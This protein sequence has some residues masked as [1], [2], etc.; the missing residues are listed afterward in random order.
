MFPLSDDV[1]KLVPGTLGMDDLSLT[2]ELV[3]LGELALLHTQLQELQGRVDLLEGG[4]LVDKV[5]DEGYADAAVVVVVGMGSGVV[6]AA[7]LVHVTVA[8]HQEVVA[9]VEPA[10]G[11]DVEGLDSPD[12]VLALGLY[13]AGLGRRVTYD[14]VTRWLD[15]QTTRAVGG[16]QGVPFRARYDVDVLGRLGEVAGHCF[17]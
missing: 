1:V 13:V 3:V 16:A 5:P 2:Y 8:A 17:K 7:T 14:G 15:L 12:V 11:L 6:P 10:L 4:I 9:D